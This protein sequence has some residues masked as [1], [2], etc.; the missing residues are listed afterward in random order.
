MSY[1]YGHKLV[2]ANTHPQTECSQ[3]PDLLRV[4]PPGLCFYKRQAVE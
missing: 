3:D 4:V 1:A 2:Q